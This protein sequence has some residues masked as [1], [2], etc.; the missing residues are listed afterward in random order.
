M[1]LIA[2]TFFR[3]LSF[4]LAALDEAIDGQDSVG[5]L[6]ECHVS[7]L[8]AGLGEPFFDS[9]ESIV[10]HVI[11]AIPAINGIEFGDGFQAC[12][13]RGSLINDPLVDTTG[14]AKTNHVGGVNGGISNS[15]ELVFRASIKQT[16]SIRVPQLTL[17]LKLNKLLLFL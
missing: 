9:V 10:S 5:G 12:R 7:K 8:P 11:F 14:K 16:S 6:I 4:W 15:N 1:Q 3:H 13:S 2:L 17:Y